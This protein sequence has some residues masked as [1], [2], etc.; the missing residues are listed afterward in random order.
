LV[1]R[2]Y[3]PARGIRF[4][5]LISWLLNYSTKQKH[6]KEYKWPVKNNKEL[7]RLKLQQLYGEQEFCSPDCKFK[8][9]IKPFNNAIY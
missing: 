2:S 9:Q 6:D 8:M 4:L 1:R 3:Y 7:T 5:E